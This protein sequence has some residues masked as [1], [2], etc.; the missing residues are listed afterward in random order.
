VIENWR[1]K[2]KL[3]VKNFTRG[4][5]FFDTT[6]HFTDFEDIVSLSQSTTET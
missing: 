1:L 6:K 4:A 5:E 2:P 3:A